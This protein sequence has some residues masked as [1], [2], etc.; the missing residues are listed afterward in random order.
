MI[1]R[2]VASILLCMITISCVSCGNSTPEAVYDENHKLV[3]SDTV[4]SVFE[5]NF[6]KAADFL[7]DENCTYSFKQTKDEKYEQ[8][9]EIG[10]WEWYLLD[11]EGEGIN[12][13]IM[14]QITRTKVDDGRCDDGIS[15]RL[16]KDNDINPEI[17][18]VTTE[19]ENKLFNAAQIAIVMTE[20]NTTD[21]EKAWEFIQSLY[22]DGESTG[23]LSWK[24]YNEELSFNLIEGDHMNVFSG[25]LIDKE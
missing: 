5:S 24:D 6:Q 11:I 10:T 13:N 15:V 7:I 25:H 21:V 4:V 16:G 1:K 14:F 18:K 20:T 9:S 3:D 22:M 17:L 19:D 12:D 23:C 8:D 2:I